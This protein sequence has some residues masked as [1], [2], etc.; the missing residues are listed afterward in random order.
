MKAAASIASLVLCSA[1]AVASPNYPK[2]TLYAGIDLRGHK[3][4]KIQ[5]GEWLKGA[6]P[7]TK[8]KVVLV[9]MW[10]TWCPGCREL[11]PELNAWQKKFGK[12]LVIIGVSGES[13]EKVRGFMQSQPMNYH[14]AVDPKQRMERAVKVE[15]IPQVLV[16]SADGTVR[17]QGFPGSQEDPL[18]DEKLASII[19]KSKRRAG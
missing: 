17:W 5:V 9:D 1:L 10:A 14:V 13:A 18:T 8:G 6:H 7:A 3:A 12:D 19:A 16:I 15:A 11:I 2:K 4:P